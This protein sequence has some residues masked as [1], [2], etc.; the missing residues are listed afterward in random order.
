MRTKIVYLSLVTVFLYT[1]QTMDGSQKLPVDRQATREAVQLY[2]KMNTKIQ[3]GIMF[4]HQDDL[5]YGHAW[6]NEANRSDVKEVCGDYPAVVG[7][8]LGHLEHGA[9]FNLDSV[10]FKEMKRYI[11]EG[12]RRGSVNTISWHGDNIVTRKSAWDCKQNTVVKSILPNGSN[13]A[14]F[15]TWLDKLAVFF[16]DLKDDKGVLIPVVFR[17]FHEHSGNWFWWCADQC[18]PEEYKQLW[19]MTY[20]YLT[21]EKGVHNL[22]FAYSPSDVDSEAD[23]LERY[24]GDQYVDVVGFDCYAGADTAGIEYY[25]K[26]MKLNLDIVTAYAAKSNKVPAVTETGLEG[27]THSGY[28]SEILY[29][30]ISRYKISYVLVWRNAWE[31][32]GHFYAPYSGHPAC[33]DF[34]SFVKKPDILMAKD[35]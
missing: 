21:Q 1:C 35:L 2:K 22:L 27:L 13:H 10:S 16:S 26:R 32:P 23:Y 30:I 31:R 25:K 4:G 3:K 6:Y 24:P 19:I 34:N 20:N 29:P 14:E 11:L 28:F 7:W 12:Y 18:T 5:A 8:E 17:M 9:S 33:G 15:L